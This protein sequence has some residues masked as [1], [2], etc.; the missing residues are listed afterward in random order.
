[1]RILITGGTGYV[2]SV[3]MDHFWPGRHA[4][5]ESIAFTFHKSRVPCA[6][7]ENQRIVSYSVDLGSEDAT[8]QNAFAKF[9]VEYAPDLILHTAAVTNSN[10]SEAEG[11]PVNVSGTELVV[12]AANQCAKV[13]VIVHMSTDWVYDGRHT[14]VTEPE[15]LLDTAFAAYGKTKLRGEL[16]YAKPEYAS[17]KERSILLRSA[18]VLGPNS[19]LIPSRGTFFNWMYSQM[20]KQNNASGTPVQL[21]S[22]EFRTPIFIRDIISFFEIVADAVQC[23]KEA[24]LAPLLGHTF[25]LAGPDRISRYELGCVTCQI[26]AMDLA[27][28]VHPVTLAQMNLGGKR[29]SDLS[30]DAAL[31]CSACPSWHR[32]SIRDAVSATVQC[33]NTQS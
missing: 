1:M 23:Q 30:M 19:M 5:C 10:C 32:T 8:V 18:L 29:P 3:S 4:F 33:M 17:V 7:T 27:A 22:D 31:L 24:V 21:F 2:G 11:Y 26:A 6:V 28:T 13:P 25:N 9:V 14:M 16:V 20:T 12:R 15:F